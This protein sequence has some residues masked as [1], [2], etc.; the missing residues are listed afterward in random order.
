MF[1]IAI[2]DTDTYEVTEFEPATEKKLLYILDGYRVD[3]NNPTS[4]SMHDTEKE[5]EK[6]VIYEGDVYKGEFGYN[7]LVARKFREV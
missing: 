5:T 3:K 1:W 7:I 2:E 6:R 4:F